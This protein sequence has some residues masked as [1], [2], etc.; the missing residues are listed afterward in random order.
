MWAGSWSCCVA[1]T[2]TST[3]TGIGSA[4]GMPSAER[5][6]ALEGLGI[7]IADRAMVTRELAKGALVQPLAAAM[8]G[9]QSYWF[10]TRP[11]QG[12]EPTLR[13]LRDWLLGA[14]AS[15]GD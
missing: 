1:A 15:D 6:A 10:V 8:P 4:Y 3:P 12:G 5:R 13:L 9:H 14:V 7:T 11:G 2:G